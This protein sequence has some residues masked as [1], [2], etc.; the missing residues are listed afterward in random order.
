MAIEKMKILGAVS[1]LPA[2]ST[3]N[4]AHLPKNWAKVDS[5]KTRILIFLIAMGADYSLYVKSIAVYAP[6]FLRYNNPVLSIVYS[7]YRIS[8]CKIMVLYCEGVKHL[9]MFILQHLT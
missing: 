5:S 6:T 7:L 8:F 9:E 3:A 4:P 1:E 2:K